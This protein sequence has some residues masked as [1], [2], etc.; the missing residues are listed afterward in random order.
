MSVILVCVAWAG[1]LCGW[2]MLHWLLLGALSLG[3]AIVSFSAS[4][5]DLLLILNVFGILAFFQIS[6][7]IGAAARSWWDERVAYGSTTTYSDQT[8]FDGESVL[9]VEDDPL[10]AALIAGEVE[11]A[12]GRPIGPA[13][14][15]SE[16][17]RQID[18]GGVEA[19]ILDLKL[20]DGPATPVALELLNRGLPFVIVS[21][22][23]APREIRQRDPGIPVFQKPVKPAVPVQ[24]LAR[25][26]R[27]IAGRRG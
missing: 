24:S 2:L 16:A 21:A 5:W 26:V 23:S 6:F 13:A 27:L 3:V 19:A 7:L 12:S 17:L 9:I 14:S 8:I 18:E 22:L 4:R 15:I 11:A 25:E 20:L 10:T 1:L